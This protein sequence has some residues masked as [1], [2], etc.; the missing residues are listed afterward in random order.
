MEGEHHPVAEVVV[1]ALAGELAPLPTPSI[2]TGGGVPEPANAGASEA[3]ATTGTAHTPVRTTARL[4]GLF[5]G[6][7]PVP[8]VP[9]TSSCEALPGGSDDLRQVLA[10]R[11]E[12]QSAVR[13]SRHCGRDCTPSV[14]HPVMILGLPEETNSTIFPTG[15]QQVPSQWPCASPAP[16]SPHVTRTYSRHPPVSA[17]VP[18]AR[19]SAKFV[20]IRSLPS[21]FARFRTSPASPAGRWARSG[22]PQERFNEQLEGRFEG[23][24]VRS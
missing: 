20:P 18:I 6:L 3:V 4:L 17:P 16:P 7:S 24:T 11:K 23:R 19:I 1:S 14:Q 9:R 13:R 12:R 15:T 22:R 5:I 8:C 10:G 2:T 21:T